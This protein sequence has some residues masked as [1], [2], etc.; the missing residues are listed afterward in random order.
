MLAGYVGHA[1]WLASDGDTESF[2]L[3]APQDTD[4]ETLT[5]KLEKPTWIYGV[6]ILW[7]RD[8]H[9]KRYAVETSVN[10]VDWVRAYVEDSGTGGQEE[11]TLPV[12]ALPSRVLFVQ[13]IMMR[14]RPNQVFGVRDV[15][16][17]G[18]SGRGTVTINAANS[19]SALEAPPNTASANTSSC[20]PLVS[21]SMSVTPTVSSVVPRRGT[22]A[23][24]TDVTVYGNFFGATASGVNV[25]FGG[26]PCTVTAMLSDSSG[27]TCKTAPSGAKNGGMKQVCA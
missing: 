8:A 3:S 26:F 17:T 19:C 5:I 27:L 20:T 25:S 14:D 9:A 15:Q 1:A 16:V 22:T 4:V 13:L 18:C 10:G 6:S 11:V 7:A 12:E 23:G 21:A 24:G 2:W